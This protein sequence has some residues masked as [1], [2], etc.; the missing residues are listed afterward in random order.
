MLT[1]MKRPAA[2]VLLLSMAA[3]T[4]LQPVKEPTGYFARKAPSFVVVTTVDS[5]ESQDPIVLQRPQLQAGT[6][7]GLSDGETVSLPISR[8]RTV[9]AVQRD[10]KL[11]AFALLGAAVGV[12]AVTYLMVGNG[13][14][15]DRSPICVPEGHRGDLPY[16]E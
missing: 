5:E 8:I 14:R 3:C 12:G 1:R 10:R 6:L 16:C 13:K 2:G 4:S 9:R 15:I 11:T 7:V